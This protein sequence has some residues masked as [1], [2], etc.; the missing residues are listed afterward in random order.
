MNTYFLSWADN[1]NTSTNGAYQFV[2]SSSQKTANN[3][4]SFTSDGI[5]LMGDS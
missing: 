2:I 3:I 5:D 1:P 4:G